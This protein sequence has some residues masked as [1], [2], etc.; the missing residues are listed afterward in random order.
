METTQK[1]IGRKEKGTC[2]SNDSKQDR[3]N[4][5]PKSEKKQKSHSPKRTMTS[6]RG[7]TSSRLIEWKFLSFEVWSLN[8]KFYCY[9]IEE[10]S[11]QFSRC[12]ILIIKIFK[13][14]SLKLFFKCSQCLFVDV[15]ELLNYWPIIGQ[16]KPKLMNSRSWNWKHLKQWFRYN[17]HRKAGCGTRP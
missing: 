10:A 8:L 14:W 6:S 9:F 4:V 12:D 15:N 11:G 1:V 17:D 7:G 3:R 13:F 5:R 16:L 2:P